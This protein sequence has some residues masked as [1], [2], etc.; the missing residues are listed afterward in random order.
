MQWMHGSLAFILR[1]FN[2]VR[3]YERYV[4]VFDTD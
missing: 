2:F 4:K 1:N 3:L